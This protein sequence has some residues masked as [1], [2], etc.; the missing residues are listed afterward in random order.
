MP[1]PEIVGHCGKK[2]RKA[3][4][5]FREYGDHRYG[6]TAHVESCPCCISKIRHSLDHNPNTCYNN[7]STSRILQQESNTPLETPSGALTELQ[8]RAQKRRNAEEAIRSMHPGQMTDDQIRD[9]MD[10]RFGA[11]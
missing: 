5:D 8:D 9:M 6:S 11:R 10:K 4:A 7:P 3:R 1:N 2:G